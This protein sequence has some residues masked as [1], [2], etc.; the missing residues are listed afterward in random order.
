MSNINS[1]NYHVVFSTYIIE[2]KLN[3]PKIALALNCSVSTLNRLLQNQSKPSEEMLKQTAIL[4]VIGFEK[5]AKL[6]EA[7]KEK[8]SE[9]IGPLVGAGLG[10]ASIPTIVGGLGTAGLS[11]A[12]IMSGLATAGA[13]VG[14][15]A[16]AGIIVVGSGAVLAGIAGYSIVRGVKYAVSGF[17]VKRKNLDKRWEI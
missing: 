2:N 1:E 6:S 5:Y 13:I 16:A 15:G 3:V 4:I 12:G 8:Y 10:L 11:G 9:K 14:G 17:K 7:E